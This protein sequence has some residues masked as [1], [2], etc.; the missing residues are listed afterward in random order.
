MHFFYLGIILFSLAGMTYMLASKIFEMKTGKTGLLTRASVIADPHIFRKVEEIKST[1]SRA[2]LENARRVLRFV[3]KYLF[4]AFGT[5]GLLVAK[6][7]GNFASRIRGK[8][9]LKGGGVASFFLK[10]VAES[11]GEDK[12]DNS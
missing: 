12:K 6:H 8:K 9:F 11:K 2:N 5:V 10:D 4:H 7:Y 3:S 1:I